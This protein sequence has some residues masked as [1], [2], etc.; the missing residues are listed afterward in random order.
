MF[1]PKSLNIL[2]R[3]DSQK[4]TPHKNDLKEDGL[5]VLE[6]I[7]KLGATTDAGSVFS[8]LLSDKFAVKKH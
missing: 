3:A 5:D 6:K 4:V 8:Q 7:D 1:L 2:Y